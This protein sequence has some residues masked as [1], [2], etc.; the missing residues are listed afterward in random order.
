M[1]IACR[2]TKGFSWPQ[3]VRSCSSHT[4]EIIVCADHALPISLVWLDRWNSLHVIFFLL[5]LRLVLVLLLLL[6]CCS[7]V[8]FSC[9]FSFFFSSFV[10]FFTFF[11][12]SS[13]SPSSSSFPFHFFPF[14][15]FLFLSFFYFFFYFFSPLISLFSSGPVNRRV[16]VSPANGSE[17]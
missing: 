8:F 6:A 5:V 17:T 14:S 9:F 2:S 15:F 13:P 1:V 4:G 7:S 3:A 16:L 12:P 10:F 11:F